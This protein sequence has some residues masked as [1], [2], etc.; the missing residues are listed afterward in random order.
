[1]TLAHFFFALRGS[2]KW[3]RSPKWAEVTGPRP[4]WAEVTCI[5]R[6]S[7]V[8][9]ISAYDHLS[10]T[11]RPKMAV[12]ITTNYFLAVIMVFKI[13]NSATPDTCLTSYHSTPVIIL[14]QYR[15]NEIMSIH[16][17]LNWPE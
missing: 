13:K 3:P 11:H 8:L 9:T 15:I 16:M 17:N 4:P 14:E 1:M 10:H 5:R 12:C 6:G 7:G 2:V